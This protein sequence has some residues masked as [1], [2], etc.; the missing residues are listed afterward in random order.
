MPTEPALE[1]LDATR[2]RDGRPV[3]AGASL[4]I[5]R[6]TLVALLGANG[7]GKSTLLALAAGVLAPDSGRVRVLGRD[8]L[9]AARD[10]RRRVGW[11]PDP[12]PLYPELRVRE[13]IAASARLRGL[14]ARDAATAAVAAIDRLALGPLADRLCGQL[15]RGESQRV[16]IAQAVAHGPELLLLDEPSAGLDPVQQARLAD[17][18]AGLRGAMTIV[19]ATH[20]LGEAATADRIV[21]LDRGR[22]RR[23]AARAE[24]PDAEAIG[25]AF[26]EIALAAPAEAA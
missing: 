24:L 15:S 22:I 8:P 12:V 10:L 1:Y 2:R 18:L 4:A 25:R 23:D 16:G 19:H 9:R 11:L 21:I 5:E 26:V 13:Q 17:L 6:G 14:P 20:H 3:L 7:A